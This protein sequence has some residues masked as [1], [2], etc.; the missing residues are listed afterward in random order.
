MVFPINYGGSCI[1]SLKPIQCLLI[2]SEIPAKLGL[3]PVQTKS[4]RELQLAL[5][6]ASVPYSFHFGIFWAPIGCGFV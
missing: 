4:P 2:F 3:N 1:F 5:V 6:E